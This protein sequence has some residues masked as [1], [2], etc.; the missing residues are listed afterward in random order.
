MSNLSEEI[1]PPRYNKEEAENILDR[2]KK[3]NLEIYNELK[4][5]IK[6]VKEFEEDLKRI[7]FNHINPRTGKAK[8]IKEK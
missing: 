5:Y 2:A 7:K 1:K 3:E 8:L 6:K 4:I